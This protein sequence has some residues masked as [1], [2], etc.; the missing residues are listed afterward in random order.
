VKCPKCGFVSYSGLEK[1]KKCGYPFA[2]AAPKGPSSSVTS[3]F[4]EGV[5]AVPTP[6]LPPPLVSREELPHSAPVLATQQLDPP[7]PPPAQTHSET[8]PEANLSQL[9]EQPQIPLEDPEVANPT[10]WNGPQ[11]WR[12]ELSERVDNFRRRRARLRPGAKPPEN[13]ELDF[14]DHAESE[15]DLPIDRLPGIH[16]DASSDFDF[17]IGGPAAVNDLDGSQREIIPF[18]DPGEGTMQFDDAS[19]EA[20]ERFTDEPPT[21]SDPLEILVGW[22]TESPAEEQEGVGE[23]YLAPLGRRFRAGLIDALVLV[24][25]AALFG[26]IFWRFCGRLSLV[27]LNLAILGVVA[28]MLVFGY[29]AVFTA[30]ATATPG[31]LWMGCEI[32]NLQGAHPTP[33]ESLWRAFGVLVSLAALML[34]F[35]WACV[36]SDNLTWHDRMSG[37]VITEDQKAAELVD[38]KAES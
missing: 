31:L 4:P 16:P 26:V 14:D 15:E 35:I 3:L 19:P 27:P 9:D 5:R 38:L 33:R 36:D 29:F 18:E 2:N 10:P 24:L 34:G 30:V 12:E 28:V 7:E 22:P 25:G 17:D 8:R 21:K 20:E 6:P 23:F 13:L 37:T 11:D 1:C 32:R